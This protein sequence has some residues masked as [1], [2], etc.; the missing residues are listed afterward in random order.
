MY[1]TVQAMR[2]ITEHY[3]TVT[4]RTIAEQF[5]YNPSYLSA[6]IKQT[7]GKNFKQLLTEY[8][9]NRAL[10]ELKSEGKTVERVAVDCGYRDLSTFYRAFA[11]RFGCT[12]REFIS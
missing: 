7:T 4:L 1:F 6:L 9:L 8:R 2:F 5:H 3:Q 12:P 11:K 10:V